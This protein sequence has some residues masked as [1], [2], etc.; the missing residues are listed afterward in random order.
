MNPEEVKAVLGVE[1]PL[2]E[3]VRILT[4][5]GFEVEEGKGRQ[6]KI[7]IPTWRKDVSIKEDLIEEVGR[8]HGYEKIDSR[9][10][11]AQIVPP[12]RNLDIFWE[13]NAKDTLQGAGFTEVYNYSFISQ[14]QADL[15][16]FKKDEL[17][18][19]ANP[20]SGKY[21]YLA[22]SLICN[23]VANVRDNLKYYK[24]VYI[25]EL[26][27]VFI[28][29]KQGVK[30]QKSLAGVLT[31]ARASHAYKKIYK[32]KKQ[33][34]FFEAK[35]V[36]E[37]LFSNMLALDV[38]YDAVQPTPEQSKA[39][40]WDLSRSA[41][42]KFRK[43][44]IGFIGFLSQEIKKAEKIKQEV[45][46]FQLDF[47]KLRRFASEEHEFETISPYPI[48]TRDLALL[49]PREV[50]IAEVLNVINRAGGETVRDVDLF[51][52][53]EGEELPEDKKNLAFHIAY[54]AVDRTLTPEEI[55]KI[56]TRITSEL[57]KEGWE[58]RK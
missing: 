56:H 30:E 24:S 19:V 43:E 38:W 20:L 45:V 14:K 57:E 58:V 47:D 28:T 8:I 6:L 5:L 52:I 50:R 31:R 54:Q 10:P 15:F 2:K 22:P 41:E 21:Q 49:V 4:V 3:I 16:G 55:E 26:G 17:V 48:A 32:N 18:E 46:V 1:V 44:E 40:T 53:Y 23:L 36:L 29:Q 33:E 13:E 35:G 34:L 42:I 27:P 7:K 39:E 11:R 25:F 9:L 37:E 12:S 51:D